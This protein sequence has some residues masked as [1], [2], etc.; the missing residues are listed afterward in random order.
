[1]PVQEMPGLPGAPAVQAAAGA[2]VQKDDNRIGCGI[3]IFR[4]S[5]YNFYNMVN[6]ADTGRDCRS[7]VKPDYDALRCMDKIHAGKTGKE[8]GS[9]KAED[10]KGRTPLQK[11]VPGSGSHYTNN[12]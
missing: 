8:V 7:A 5:S 4:G 2:G 1:M 9:G 11:D 3:F 6:G 10:G 12:Q